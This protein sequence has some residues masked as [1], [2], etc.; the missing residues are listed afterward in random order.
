MR[1]VGY[2]AG[3]AL[4]DIQKRVVIRNV[5]MPEVPLCA[6]RLQPR[7]HRKRGHAL[8]GGTLWQSMFL[9]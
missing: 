8:H 6:T 9:L 5:Y 7:H 4:T 2:D 1:W 3:M